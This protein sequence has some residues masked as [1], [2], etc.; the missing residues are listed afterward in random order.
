M[1]SLCANVIYRYWETGFS[2]YNRANVLMLISLCPVMHGIPNEQKQ[3]F[4]LNQ[5]VISPRGQDLH[6]GLCSQNRECVRGWWPAMGEVTGVTTKWWWTRKGINFPLFKL[7]KPNAMPQSVDL[8]WGKRW[9]KRKYSWPSI[10]SSPTSSGS[11]DLK[12]KI[13]EKKN[14]R[15]FQKAK[16]DFAVHWQLFA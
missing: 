16:R 4:P 11:T 6:T 14:S 13:F 10:S 7:E 15:K 2:I 8:L 9:S 5:G 12:S 1:Y 3:W